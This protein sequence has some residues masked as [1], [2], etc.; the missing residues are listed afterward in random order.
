MR[1]KFQYSA[2]GS[3]LTHFFEPHQTFWQKATLKMM[4]TAVKTGTPV[5]KCTLYKYL[6]HTLQ[7][8]SVDITRNF[9]L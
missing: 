8:R 2:Q 4:D 6:P 3:A 1:E 5:K 9:A 7:C